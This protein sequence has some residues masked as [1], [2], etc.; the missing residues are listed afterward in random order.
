MLKLVRKRKGQR[1]FTLI[2]VML[3]AGIFLIGFTALTAFLS[4]G[5]KLRREAANTSLATNLAANQ[6]EL[7]RVTPFIDIADSS[8]GFDTRGVRLGPTPVAGTYYTVRTTTTPNLTFVDCEVVVSWI[9]GHGFT[10]S[11]RMSS[12]ITDEE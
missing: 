3:S 6:L 7:L 11:L 5:S 9:G 10:K 12:R 8:I 4:A 2:E 1:G